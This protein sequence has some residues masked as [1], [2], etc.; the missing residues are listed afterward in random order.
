MIIEVAFVR[1][2]VLT[3]SIECVVGRGCDSNESEDERV[4]LVLGWT[5]RVD[6]IS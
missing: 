3:C 6:W 1:T 4:R 2:W 5:A